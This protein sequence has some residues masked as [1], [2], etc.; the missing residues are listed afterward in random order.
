MAASRATLGYLTKQIAALPLAVPQLQRTALKG[1]VLSFNALL[2]M[3]LAGIFSLVGSSL[4][5]RS[6]IRQQEADHG[7]HPDHVLTMR[8]PIG[9]PQV[10]RA[11]TT[12]RGRWPTTRDYW[13]RLRRIPGIR[14]I[15]V[16]NNPPLTNVN[17]ATGPARPP[18]PSLTRL[19]PAEQQRA[20]I[21][22]RDQQ[23][24]P[25]R[26]QDDGEAL[27]SLW[28]PPAP[29]GGPRFSGRFPPG[30]SRRRPSAGPATSARL[31]LAG[32]IRNCVHRSM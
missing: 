13:M 18:L 12:G 6:L 20:D 15:A 16:V 22:T 11:A 17:T 4:T 3:V 5:I 14:A 2:C 19:C 7:F 23:H 28:D 30:V 27:L 21:G 10:R 26:N 9:S 24:Q 32:V 31:R 25:N 29:T 1:R 8:V